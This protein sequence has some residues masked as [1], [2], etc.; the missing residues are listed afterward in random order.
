MPFS[1][2]TFGESDSFEVGRCACNGVHPHRTSARTA[3][4]QP[5]FFVDLRDQCPSKMC[6]VMDGPKGVGGI[7]ESLQSN[8]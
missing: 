2:V 8:P 3:D 4:T 5:T 1:A 7:V 6:V